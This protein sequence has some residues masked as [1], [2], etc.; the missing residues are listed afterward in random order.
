MGTVIARALVLVL[1]AAQGENAFCQSKPKP[2]QG[3]ADAP[4]Q[5]Q[6][7]TAPP[8]QSQ[9]LPVQQPQ[10]QKPAG[11][12]ST[13]A[14]APGEVFLMPVPK[15]WKQV[16]VDQNYNIRTV[17]FVPEGKTPEKAEEML[18]SLV[19]SFV[20]D[21]PLEGFLMQAVQLPKD[22]CQDVMVTPPSK[23]LINGYES[24][25]TTRFC[26]KNKKSGQGEV[27]MFKLIQGKF[28]LYI[29]ERTWRVKPYSK[30]KQPVEKDVFE[31]W[32]QYMRAVT[33]Y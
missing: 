32:A 1:L 33:L 30:D 4:L 15:G 28:G 20:K 17:Q 9:Q 2:A 21:A 23:G 18:R 12:A 5:T 14:P 3:T 26:T 7:P 6:K 22:E 16:S 24:I 8:V 11:S 31:N 10:I 19:L 29:G 13:A 27:T 25:F